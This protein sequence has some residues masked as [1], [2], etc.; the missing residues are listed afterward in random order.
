M[1]EDVHQ[2]LAWSMGMHTEAK[3]WWHMFGSLINDLVGREKID[4]QYLQRKCIPL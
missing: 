4:V 2:E 1:P 3:K